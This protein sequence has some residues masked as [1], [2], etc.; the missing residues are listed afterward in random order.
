VKQDSVHLLDICSAKIEHLNLKNIVSD[1]TTK[2][3]IVVSIS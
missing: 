1:P 3:K 2:T